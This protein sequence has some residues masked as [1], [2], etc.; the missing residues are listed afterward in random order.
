MIDERRSA[1]WFA[2]LTL[3]SVALA[4]G[5]CKEELG[6]EHLPVAPVDGW[7]TERGRPVRGGWIEFF[8]V[9][10]GKGDIRSA[11]LKPDGSFHADRVAVGLNLIRLV[12]TDIQNIDAA[13]LFGSYQ[14]PIRR[15][16]PA[17]RGDPLGIEL[18]D[19]AIRWEQ[20]R[21]RHAA[22]QSEGPGETQ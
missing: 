19:E 6:P 13:H 15:T 20:E 22:W 4:A 3:A 5:G 14:S 12:N 21:P 1:F 7:V 8:P 10:G 9:D 18:V 2:A 11:R 16:I 17:D